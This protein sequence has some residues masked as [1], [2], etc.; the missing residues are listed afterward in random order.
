[1]KGTPCERVRERLLDLRH[2]ELGPRARARIEAHLEGCEGCRAERR[3]LEVD[4]A[5]LRGIERVPPSSPTMAARVRV[6]LDA[7]SASRAPAAMR[8]P[9]LAGLA[10]AA[11]VVL[12]IVASRGPSDVGEPAP[13][14]DPGPD[15]VASAP[16]PGPLSPAGGWMVALD[17]GWVSVPEEEAVELTRALERATLAA[18]DWNGTSTD[19][20]GWGVVGIELTTDEWQGLHAALARE[21][22]EPDAD[23]L[24]RWQL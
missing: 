5:L 16:S 21:M 8:R 4:L 6:A 20:D 18:V 14:E 23:F 10:L 9:A 3:A 12:A 7:E 24:R 17:E 11:G 2:D 1:M 22:G 19:P 13:H 15:A